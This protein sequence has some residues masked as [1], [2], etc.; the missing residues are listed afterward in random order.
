[1]DKTLE[2]IEK[3]AKSM[4]VAVEKLI[5]FYSARAIGDAIGDFVIATFFILLAIFLAFVS[6][7]RYQVDNDGA[8]VLGWFVGA[9][10]IVST[11]VACVI[12]NNGIIKLM[13]PQAYAVDSILR[14]IRGQ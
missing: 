9:F 4:G 7:N 3:L 11:W 14:A 2:L 10:S 8:R 12:V 13:S 5:E 1:M 6:K